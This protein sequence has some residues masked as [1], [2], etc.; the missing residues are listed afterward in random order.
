MREVKKISCF[1]G[2]I[3]VRYV[4]VNKILIFFL[5]IIY[6]SSART[7]QEKLKFHKER[8]AESPRITAKEHREGLKKLPK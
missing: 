1:F 5:S 8:K 7:L 4:K 2:S 3:W 6:F